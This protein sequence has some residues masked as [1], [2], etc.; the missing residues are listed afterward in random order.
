MRYTIKGD[1]DC[2]LLEVYLSPTE[3]IKIERGSMV[4]LS[5]VSLE[6]KMNSSKKG[7]GGLLSSIGRSLTSGESMF[8]THA[9]AIGPNA[10]IGVAPAI[11]GKL[12]ALQVGGAT[13]YCLNTGAFVAC[14]GTVDYIMQSQDLGKAFFG[15]TGGLFVMKTTG[16]GDIIVSSFG[17]ILPVQVTSDRPMTIDNEHVVCWDAN[18]DYHIEI[19]SGTFGFTTGE[20]LVNVF[21]GNGT[22]YIQT[23]NIHNLAD[24]LRPYFPQNNGN[25]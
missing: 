3:T 8:I 12:T 15:G 21:H 9:Q 18:L 24:A 19:A 20:G 6:G 10:F 11:P 2:P 4:Y 1:S 13:Q 5:N 7:F 22:V 17:D 25:N 23:R 16:N 14:D